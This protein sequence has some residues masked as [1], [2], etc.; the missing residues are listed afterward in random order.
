MIGRIEVLLRKTRQWISRS[1]WVIRLLH[2][3]KS[4]ETAATSG[5]I[6]IQVDGLSY[7]QLNR[8]LEK[9]RMP[10]LRKLLNREHYRLHTLYSGMPSST[11]AFQGE[12]LY[13]I[14]S[15]VPA[16]G[17]LDRASG[18]VIRMFDPG[19]AESVERKLETKGKPLLKGGSAYS[20]CYTGGAGESHFCAS[21]LGWG[22]LMRAANPF[23]LSFLIL[24]NAYSFMR[25][26][27]LLV[28]EFFLA[29]FDCVSGLMDG[30]DFAKELKF[31]PTRTAICIL[32]RELITI[33]AKI[34]IA[35]GLPIV[36]LNLIGYDEQAHR[37]G[38]SSRFAHWALKGID[39]AIARIW[40][41]AK[42]SARR[43]Y[44][45]WVYS[46]HGQEE[47]IP[48]PRQYGRT[49]EKAVADVFGGLEN[50]RDEV[51]S[52]NLR[53]IQFQ[54]ARQLGGNK[55]Q[56]L[57][58]LRREN[59]EK[60]ETSRLV[61]TAI[62]PLGMIYVP[63]GLVPADRRRL[64]KKLV[65][66]AN[67]PLVL[68]TDGPGRLRAWTE[69]GEFVLPEQ[70][71]KILGAD[72]PFL[73]AVTHDLIELCHHPD[74][75]DFVI[76]G[77]RTGAK[78]YSFPMEHG[79]HAGP[80]SEET[81]AFALLPGDT[82]L[83]ERD[84]DYLRPLDFRNAAFHAIGRSEI[85]CSAETDW[86]TAERQTLRIMTYNTHSCIGMDGKLSPKRIARVIARHAPDII[87]LQELD[88]G[89]SRSGRVHQ[90]HRI[91]KYLQMECHFHPTIR[92]E[93]GLY[94]NAI[95]THL[96]MRLI[97]AKRLPGLLNKPYI[98]PRGVI[99]VAIE[100]NGTEI[101]F[102]T[103]HL[104]LRPNERQAQAE[105]LLGPDWLSHPDCRGPIIL[106]GD[107]NALPSSPVCLKLRSRL[108]DAQIELDSHIPKSTFFG[109]YPFARI[110]HV[111]VD[112]GIEVV[113]IEVPGTEL[114][115][116]ASDH[117]P[118]IAEVRIPEKV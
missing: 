47:T 93:E 38:P 1:E 61:V 95:L 45:I 71:E 118:L 78:P 110:D 31:V 98:E 82:F 59:K 27:V 83:P 10:F 19:S 109:R 54:R 50:D 66:S 77:W 7:T 102:I 53:G 91:A 49:I 106:C 103:T 20:D 3:P 36:H 94:G 37:R 24:S 100:A 57:F 69:Q 60:P 55:F 79:A 62:G 74:A 64:A 67:I 39:D 104:G 107:F 42:H 111:F 56:K 11:P 32:L 97:K 105:A 87:A 4:R 84:R 18:Q 86:K 96:P 22:A 85:K 75:G 89:R 52:E 116:V 40:H 13:G 26:A 68:T 99:W 88:V 34:D 29:V 46:D 43:D 117:L 33:G 115:N 101:Q 51:R 9:G 72:H 12:L 70:N 113:D 6:M 17:Y 112:P 58:P 5:L 15:A 81:R 92:M 14:K 2:L 25:A 41:A 48:Y 63:G 108:H 16:F 8:A 44:D 73:D 76:S 30:H 23:A 114:A 35:R 90:A 80:G 21:S 65:N 28:L